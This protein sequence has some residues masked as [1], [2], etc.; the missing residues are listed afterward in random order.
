MGH[1]ACH[2]ASTWTAHQVA[3]RAANNH[4]VTQL[5]DG[6]ATKEMVYRDSTAERPTFRKR[7]PTRITGDVEERH[8]PAA[9]AA[10]PQTELEEPRPWRAKLTCTRPQSQLASDR[11]RTAKRKALETAESLKEQADDKTRVARWIAS[12]RLNPSANQPAA[13]RMHALRARLRDKLE[14]S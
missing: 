5:V 6:G 10:S 11:A 3:L 13:E 7:K 12:R 9:S 1:Q 14:G 8:L 2:D 4:S